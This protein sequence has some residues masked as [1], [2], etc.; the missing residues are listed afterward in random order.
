MVEAADMTIWRFA[1]DNGYTIVTRDSD[2]H[3]AGHGT[4]H[5]I[6]D[7]KPVPV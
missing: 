4:L 2:F 3:E 5:N 6:T 1:R 7:F